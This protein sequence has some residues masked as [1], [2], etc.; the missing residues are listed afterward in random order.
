MRVALV[1]SLVIVRSVGKR[2]GKDERYREKR[3]VPARWTWRKLCLATDEHRQILACERTAPDVGDPFAVADLLAQAA[4]R[5]T[6]PGLR[7]NAPSAFS[8]TP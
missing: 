2:P 4:T 8:A 3:D 1:A 7:P 5:A 6:M